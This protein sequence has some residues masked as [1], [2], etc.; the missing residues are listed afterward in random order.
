MYIISMYTLMTTGVDKNILLRILKFYSMRGNMHFLNNSYL[1]GRKQVVNSA[2]YES[3]WKKCQ[4]TR[5]SARAIINRMHIKYLQNN[6][7]LNVLNFAD[8]F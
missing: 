1:D 5:L 8:D 3:T 2:G 4:V 7:C 6:T